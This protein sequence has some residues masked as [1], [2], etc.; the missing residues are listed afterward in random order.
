MISHHAQALVMVDMTRGR[1]LSSEVKAL[2][3]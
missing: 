2:T 3:G 1:H